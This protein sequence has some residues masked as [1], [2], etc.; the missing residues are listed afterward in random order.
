MLFLKIWFNCQ[1]LR[2]CFPTIM[3]KIMSYTTRKDSP[4]SFN[5][6]LPISATTTTSLQ[7]CP[8]L[9]ALLQ[10]DELTRRGNGSPT[11]LYH[12][13][14]H[15]SGFAVSLGPPP[16]R[17]TVKKAANHENH[18]KEI[19]RKK[20]NVR[21]DSW[22]DSLRPAMNSPVGH[23]SPASSRSATPNPYIRPTPVVP[24]INTFGA[25]TA[26]KYFS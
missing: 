18:V 16:P 22:P 8:N 19:R 23:S 11:G 13:I 14:S 10:H 20:S 2:T 24:T 21:S 12:P 26:G 9:E 17:N 1:L 6:V 3:S 4:S 25:R 5:V 15:S 7:I